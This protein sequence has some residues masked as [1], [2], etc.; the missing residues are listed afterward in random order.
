MSEHIFQPL[1]PDHPAIGNP[2]GHC[3]NSFQAGDQT[4]LI[5]KPGGEVD[6]FT[7]E[8]ILVHAPRI[9]RPTP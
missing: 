8:A 9:E 7:V 5:T 3:G 2:C 4:T 6:G 1:H